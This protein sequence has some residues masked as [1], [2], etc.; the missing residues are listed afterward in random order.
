[1]KAIEV[2]NLSYIYPDG[3]KG[4][5][6]IN[7]SVEKG[8]T[9]SII[10]PNG[11]GKTTLLLAICGIIPAKGTVKIFGE[12][13][14]KRNIKELRRNLGFVFQDPDDQLFMPT[15]YEDI[16]FGPINLGLSEEEVPQVVKD[17]LLNVGL[18]DFEKRVSHHLSFGEKKRISLATVL[19]MRTKILL[20]DEPT[21]NL[22]PRTRREFIKLLQDIKC[23]KVIVGHDLAMIKELSHRSLLLNEGRKIAEGISSELLKDEKLLKTNG[24]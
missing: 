15:V 16:A 6:D 8:E 24:L 2:E 3:T 9:F 20:L 13:L 14:T 1:M 19:A 22:D 23:T 4:L 7:F 12:Q 10:G 18:V 5:D 21:S 17:A 11:A